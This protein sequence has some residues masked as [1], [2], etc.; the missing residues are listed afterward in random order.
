[1]KKKV[2]VKAAWLVTVAVVGSRIG[3][4]LTAS[5]TSVP[6]SI[7]APIL[8]ERRHE[9]MWMSR[10]KFDEVAK[11]VYEEGYKQGYL[12]GQLRTMQDILR[13]RRILESEPAGILAEQIEEILKKKGVNDG[14]S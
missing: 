8:L 1:M 5:V 10:K 4:S 7:S 3:K 11:K 13:W 14:K 12:Q 2:E 9:T 6:E